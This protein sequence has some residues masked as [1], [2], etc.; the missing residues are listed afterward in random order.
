MQLAVDK[1][2]RAEPAEVD[3]ADYFPHTAEDVE[4]LYSRLREHAAAIKNPWLNR[5]AS[6]RDRGPGDC[7]APEARAG[8]QD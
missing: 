8:G 6:E 1:V 2:R 3:L 4:E 5:L 7:A